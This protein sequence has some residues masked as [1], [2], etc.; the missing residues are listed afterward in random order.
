M[1]NIISKKL[2]IK[3]KLLKLEED[4]QKEIKLLDELRIRI[5][6]KYM[7]IYAILFSIFIAITFGVFQMDNTSI[8]NTFMNG[9]TIILICISA[10]FLVLLVAE[11]F[12]STINNIRIRRATIRLSKLKEKQK[13][14]IGIYKKDNN[15]A[16][17]KTIIEKY[18]E[19]ESRDSFFT[20]VQKKRKDVVEKISDYVLAN[21]PSKMNALICNK[22]GLHNGLVDPANNIEYFYCYDCKAR[23]DRNM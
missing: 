10:V 1:G 6:R 5:G 12:T 18:E 9:A 21:D 7:Q 11:L 4:I 8:N 14:L 3:D 15:F 20:Q 17:A 13:E 16:F 22:C 2:S 19:E 23:N